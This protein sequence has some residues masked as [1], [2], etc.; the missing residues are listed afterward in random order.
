MKHKAIITIEMEPEDRT[1]CDI[2]VEME[3]AI[4]KDQDNVAAGLAMGMIKMLQGK[5]NDETP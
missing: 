2:T 1:V 5:A 3:P 4:S